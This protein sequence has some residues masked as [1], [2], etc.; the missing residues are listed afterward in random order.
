MRL[1]MKPGVER[2]C[3]GVLPQRA[4]R[5]NTACATSGAVPRPDTTST[6]F[7]SGT[8]L[9]K[10]MPTSRS[11]RCMP[12]ARAVTEIDEVLVAMT[13]SSGSSASSSA[14][15]VRFTSRFSTM[16][17]MTRSAGCSAA[18]GLM[19]A[20]VAATASALS[21]PLATRPSSVAA[22]LALAASAAPSRVSNSATSWP[23]WAATCAMPA[24]IRPAPTTRTWAVSRFIRKPSSSACVCPGRRQSLRGPRAC[25]AR[26]RWS[27]RSARARRQ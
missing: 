16:A 10:C 3:T 21:L 9:K 20:S 1:T 19:R 7:I 15:S 25:C 17:S 27:R 2:A 23:A 6:S 14:K 26:G 13:A 12:R 5:S 8:G 24:P 18:T 4:A 11:G 22:S